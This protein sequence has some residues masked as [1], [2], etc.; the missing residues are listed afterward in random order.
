[1]REGA[2]VLNKPLKDKEAGS[3][4]KLHAVV[5]DEALGDDSEAE[6]R[7]VD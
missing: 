2:P 5:D 7:Y 6:G 4:G 3:G 1:M